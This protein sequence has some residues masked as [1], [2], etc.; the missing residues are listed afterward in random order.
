MNKSQIMLSTLVL[1]CLAACGQKPATVV[2]EIN[3]SD[4]KLPD[5]IAEISGFSDGEPWGRWSDA[6]ISSTAKIRFKQ[7]L[8]TH[9]SII[10]TGQTIAGNEYSVIKIGNFQDQ[11]YLPSLKEE[12]IVDVTLDKPEDTIELIP[13]KPATP[14]SLGLN[15]DA[16]KLGIGLA[17]LRIEK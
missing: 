2:T 11:V 14:K 3:F 7:S 15:D 5:S 1:L 13:P 17:T 16:R 4:P 12:A 8:P 6:N 9:F 10:L